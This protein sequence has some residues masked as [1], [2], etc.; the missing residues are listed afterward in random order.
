M[1]LAV[2]NR[3]STHQPVD[4]S[5]CARQQCSDRSTAPLLPT[6]HALARGFDTEFAHAV[7]VRANI[8]MAPI[9]NVVTVIPGTLDP[10]HVVVLGNHRDAW[11]AGAIDP[12]YGDFGTHCRP[13]YIFINVD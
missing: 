6:F 2:V 5:D 9:W 8:T 10:E 4:D 11:V 3:F 7:I 13:C 1:E 12:T